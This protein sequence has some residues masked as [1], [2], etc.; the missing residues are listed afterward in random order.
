MRKNALGRLLAV[1]PLR[2]SVAG[3]VLGCLMFWLGFRQAES[4]AVE[5]DTDPATGD[6]VRLII[7]DNRGM[8]IRVFAHSDLREAGIPVIT[9]D[10]YE[11]DR[12]LSW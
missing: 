8:E 5:P 6:A 11:M 2:L 10:R 9:L 1:M 12:V 7:R 3:L 4:R